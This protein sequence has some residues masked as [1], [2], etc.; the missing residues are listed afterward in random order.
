MDFKH[1]VKARAYKIAER[2][3]VIY[4]YM[5]EQQD[6]PPPMPAVAIS[7]PRRGFLGSRP[8]VSSLRLPRGRALG[9]RRQNT[10]PPY[11]HRVLGI[12]NS[13]FARR[14]VR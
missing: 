11:Q 2:N 6:A 1:K 10:G 14:K 9:S 12:F 3:G 4:V 13:S 5:G 7:L 8:T